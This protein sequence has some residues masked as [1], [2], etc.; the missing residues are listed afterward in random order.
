MHLPMNLQPRCSNTDDKL[1]IKITRISSASS[2]Y[3]GVDDIRVAQLQ[4]IEIVAYDTTLSEDSS[5]SIS[6]DIYV[7]E[8]PSSSVSVTVTADDQILVNGQSEITLVFN[9]PV[10]PAAPQTV[11]VT[12]VDDSVSEG[13][14]T[15]LI[16]HTSGSSLDAYNEL[17]LPNLEVSI[18]DN[19]MPVNFVSDVFV[20]GQEGA[21]GTSNYR[22]PGMTVAPDGS[23]LAFAEGRRN[24]GDPGAALPIDMVMKRS[25]D[26]GQTW[27]PLVVLHQSTFDYSDPRPIT[28]SADRQCI[29][30]LY[31]VAGLMRTILCTGRTG[32]YFF[33]NVSPDY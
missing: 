26:Q 20:G 28:D 25:I 29:S 33:R 18:V 10:D 2:A 22:I 11:T 23:I 27:Q 8:S 13:T 17:N 6:Y 9:P 24:G 14:H 7:K 12:A 5:S 15:G 19:D 31:T 3:L 30:A 32:K 21:E 16:S 1:F 4:P